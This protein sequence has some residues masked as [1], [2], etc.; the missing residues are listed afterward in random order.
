EA[1]ARER[2]GRPCLAGADC[3]VARER[4]PAPHQGD[5]AALGQGLGQQRGRGISEH[6][7]AAGGQ[8]SPRRGEEVERGSARTGTFGGG[9]SGTA[10]CLVFGGWWLG[11]ASATMHRSTKHQ[12]TNPPNTL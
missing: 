2:S 12:T 11:A 5:G 8:F 4:R 1:T 7:R 3:P 9:V 6:Q 10:E